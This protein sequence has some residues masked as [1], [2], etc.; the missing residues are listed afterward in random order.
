MKLI[1]SILAVCMAALVLVVTTGFSLSQHFCGGELLYSSLL[2]NAKACKM[3]GHT[4][5]LPGN[6]EEIPGGMDQLPPCHKQD[7][8]A[9]SFSKKTCCE[10]YQADVAGKDIPAPLKK[11]ENLLPSVKFLA[12]FTYAFLS[13][14]F[15]SV[16]KFHVA[17]H[18]P[19]LIPRDLP[20]LFQSFLI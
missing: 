7:S 6:A 19:P 16:R 15:Q 20:V 18:S 11:G 3:A 1:R 14:S 17:A 2:G 10:D 4:E 12:A 13:P 9:D 5:G 8:A